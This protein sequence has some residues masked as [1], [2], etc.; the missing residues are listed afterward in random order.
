MRDSSNPSS[1][2]L[3]SSAPPLFLSTQKG[4][5]EAQGLVYMSV[6]TLQ[7]PQRDLLRASGSLLY[8]AF[9]FTLSSFVLLEAESNILLWCNSG[10]FPL[11]FRFSLKRQ[12]L[13]LGAML[14]HNVIVQ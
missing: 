7:C 8:I 12:P 11:C 2:S 1:H 5:A 13:I 10:V 14:A 6:T 9:I 4:T 3:L